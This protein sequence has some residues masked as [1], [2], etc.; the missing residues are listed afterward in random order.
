MR[1]RRSPLILILIVVGLGSVLAGCGSSD[2]TSSSDT[3]GIVTTTT[4]GATIPE[5]LRPL[6][7][8]LTD[9]EPIDQVQPRNVGEWS[10][11]RSRVVEAATATAAAYLRAAEIAPSAMV[12]SLRTM[13]AY[14]TAILDATVD[15]ESFTI[16]TSTIASY[17][18]KVGASLAM[19]TVEAW[20]RENCT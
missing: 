11:E 1:R 7:T 14:V 13:S 20:K 18:D 16:A 10:V 15:A 6:C 2:S 9:A 17:R 12:A 19:A 4:P 8:I 5:A 3:T